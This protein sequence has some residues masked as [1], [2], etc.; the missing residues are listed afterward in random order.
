MELPTLTHRPFIPTSLEDKK[1]SSLPLSKQRNYLVINAKIESDSNSNDSSKTK[2]TWI[3][4]PNTA[5]GHVLWFFCGNH[6]KIKEA[7]KTQDPHANEENLESLRWS[8]LS[9]Q[10]VWYSIQGKAENQSVKQNNPIV[11]TIQLQ[12]SAKSEIIEQAINNIFSTPSISYKN[13]DNPLKVTKTRKIVADLVDHHPL[14]LSKKQLTTDEAKE[15]LRDVLRWVA[16][17]QLNNYDQDKIFFLDDAKESIYTSNDRELPQLSGYWTTKANNA[18][19]NL[20]KAEHLFGKDSE[21]AREW[22]AR[23]EKAKE[24]SQ[25]ISQHLQKKNVSREIKAKSNLTK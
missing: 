15:V 5:W 21:I 8:P 14:I 11:E 19:G 7:I 18:N 12:H 3:T 16:Y 24:E 9:A 25:K 17:E 6:N 20:T 1:P 4:T 10:A 2:V 23:Y 13:S 22:K